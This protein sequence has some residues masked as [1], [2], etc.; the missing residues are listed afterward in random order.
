MTGDG[1]GT[2]VSHFDGTSKKK[3]VKHG[4]KQ[5][6]RFGHVRVEKQ[7]GVEVEIC[8]NNFHFDSVVISS[9][10]LI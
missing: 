7:V 1:E 2:D 3:R 4:S 8:T 6:L 10:T 5:S 9:I